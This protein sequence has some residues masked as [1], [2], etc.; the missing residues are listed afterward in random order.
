MKHLY[1][2]E[3]GKARLMSRMLTRKDKLLK[4]AKKAW[5]SD[6]INPR[7]NWQEYQSKFKT[8]QQRGAIRLRMFSGHIFVFDE[9]D[10]EIRLVTVIKPLESKLP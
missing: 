7:L 2:T 3:H 6:Y 9:L 1:L 5:V 10:S 8:Y 4:V